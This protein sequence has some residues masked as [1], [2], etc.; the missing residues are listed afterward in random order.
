MLAMDSE[1]ME[2]MAGLMKIRMCDCQPCVEG[3]EDLNGQVPCWSNDLQGERDAKGSILALGG[4][5]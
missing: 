2:E 1:Q 3:T 5:A 4:H